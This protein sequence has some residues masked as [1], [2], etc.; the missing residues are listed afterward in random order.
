MPLKL[1]HCP[2]LSTLPACVLTSPAACES[3]PSTN[4]RSGRPGKIP[5]PPTSGKKAFINVVM[6]VNVACRSGLTNQI[7]QG[8]GAT[9]SGP[10]ASVRRRPRLRLDSQV[11]W[12]GRAQGP[13]WIGRS[14]PA[15]WS[16][17][18]DCRPMHQS[19]VHVCKL[20]QAQKMFNVIRYT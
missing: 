1:R 13:V 14:S 5:C 10:P 18:T 6:I 3:V 7:H 12:P 19:P 11:E 8:G 15:T 20:E 16:R 2:V 9:H 4:P 17:C